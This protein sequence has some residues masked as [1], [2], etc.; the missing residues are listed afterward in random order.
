MEQFKDHTLLRKIA[1]VLKGLREGAGLTQIDVYNNTNIH[2]GRIE[3]A[4]AN[5]TISTLSLLCRYFN[6]KLSDFLKMVEEQK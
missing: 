2:V 4:K 1:L 5:V 6:I 3:S